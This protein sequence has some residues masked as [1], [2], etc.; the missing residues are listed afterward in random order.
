MILVIDNYDSFTFNLV[1]LIG[2]L[3]AKVHVVRN[4][5]ISVAGAL[6]MAPAGILLSPGPCSPA[7]AG[8]CVDLVGAAR[9]AG[10]PLFGVCLGHQAIIAAAGGEV[11]RAGRQMHG[12][13]SPITHAGAGVF[14]GV[15]SPFQATRYHSLA[16]R[17]ASLPA[18]LH[19]TAEAADD[20]EIMGVMWGDV[21]CQGVQFHPESIA[22][23]HGSRL[24][25]NFLL[26]TNAPGSSA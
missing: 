17:R 8:I 20:G 7:E 26:L 23:E 6:A 14:T 15:P 4:D 12:R 25:Q 18:D 10:V 1:H 5:A 21:R 24:M 11:V 9:R 2:G 3:G 13:L 22:S 19:I 16:G